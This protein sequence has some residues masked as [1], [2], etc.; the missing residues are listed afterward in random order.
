LLHRAYAGRNKLLGV[1]DHGLAC[2]EVG[3]DRFEPFTLIFE[4]VFDFVDAWGKCVCTARFG[5]AH[6]HLAHCLLAAREVDDLAGCDID[7]RSELF[8][9]DEIVFYLARHIG[10]PSWVAF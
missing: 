4:I 2:S 9:L 5:D 3:R 7:F 1:F 10:N 6:G 8:N